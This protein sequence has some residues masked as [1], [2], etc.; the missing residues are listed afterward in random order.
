MP[1]KS[2][3]VNLIVDLGKQLGYEVVT[4]VEASES[5]WVDVVW[6]DKRLPT[7]A[8]SSAKPKIRFAPVLPVVGFEVELRTALN[9][10]HVKGSVSNLNN[11]GASLGVI[12]I[13]VEN[14][15]ALQKQPAHASKSADVVEKVL[16]ERI[17]RWVYAEAQP[18][19][20]IIV[21]FE[22]EVSAWAG[23]LHELSVAG[24]GQV[25]GYAS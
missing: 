19:G 24:G 1:S 4:E 14:L 23:K 15:S 25:L 6:F 16:R 12:V 11:L 3:L 21:M 7:R 17:Y 5:A 10:K 9:A 20:R 13:G 2:P 22:H 8:L 18:K